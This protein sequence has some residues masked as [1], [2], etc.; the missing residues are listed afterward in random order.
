MQEEIEIETRRVSED[1]FIPVSSQGHNFILVSF[2][3]P[4]HTPESSCPAG[5]ADSAVTRCELR[6]TPDTHTQEQ[7][8]DTRRCVEK[9][10]PIGRVEHS[11]E[12]PMG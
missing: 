11:A 10:Q 9:Q 2:M 1:S 12:R 7:P 4:Y 8:T 3:K 6:T 5:P